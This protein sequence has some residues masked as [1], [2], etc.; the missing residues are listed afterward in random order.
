MYLYRSQASR[1]GS[2]SLTDRQDFIII[3]ITA[4]TRLVYNPVGI[5]SSRRMVSNLKHAAARCLK[6]CQQDPCK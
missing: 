5:L 1:R 6:H 2:V 3:I 4:I